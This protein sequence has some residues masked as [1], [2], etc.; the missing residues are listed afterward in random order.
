MGRRTGA[1]DST[2]V[3]G[4]SLSP[5]LELDF[6]SSRA[7]RLGRCDPAKGP[8]LLWS[9]RTKS[10]LSPAKTSRSYTLRAS[11]RTTVWLRMADVH[12]TDLPLASVASDNPRYTRMKEACFG[13]LDL[14]VGDRDLGPIRKAAPTR[15]PSIASVWSS[16]LARDRQALE[17]HSSLT[18]R[19]S[20]VMIEGRFLRRKGGS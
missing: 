18:G 6:F 19:V 4:K 14:E 3:C 16:R 10:G 11:N 20:E 1:A 17:R 5:S 13:K 2:T 12:H 9:E 15:S 8:R 7:T